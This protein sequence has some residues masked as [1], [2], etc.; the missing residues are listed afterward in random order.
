MQPAGN[1]SAIIIYIMFYLYDVGIRW[2]QDL[3]FVPI[4]FYSKTCDEIT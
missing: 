2:S 3:W 1:R 4:I